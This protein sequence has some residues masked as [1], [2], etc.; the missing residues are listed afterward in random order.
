MG[1]CVCKDGRQEGTE[2]A[3]DN[4]AASNRS[5]QGSGPSTLTPVLCVAENLNPSDCMC[6]T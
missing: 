3:I 6:T 4:A 1:S 5:S 2:L